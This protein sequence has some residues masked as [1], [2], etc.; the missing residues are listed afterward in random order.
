MSLIECKHSQ[1]LDQIETSR[2]ALNELSKTLPLYSATMILKSRELDH[3]LN[4]YEL[5][6]QLKSH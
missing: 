6:T 3:L 4:E 5:I 2:S 1:L